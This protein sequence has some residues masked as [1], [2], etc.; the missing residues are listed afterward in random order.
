[1]TDEHAPRFNALD[2]GL[3]RRYIDHDMVDIGQWNRARAEQGIVGT[4]RE[5]GGHL[6]TMGSLKEGWSHLEWYEA[7]CI[8]CGHEFA[9]P[10]G[11]TLRRSSRHTELPPGW[12]DL[13]QQAMKERG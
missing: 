5:C 2:H 3:Y 4:C 10:S 6:R 8:L 9:C 12:W 7:K 1:M 11:R 13:R